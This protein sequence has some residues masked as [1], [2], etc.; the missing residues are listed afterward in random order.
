MDGNTTIGAARRSLAAFAVVAALAATGA[1][2]AESATKAQ[3]EFVST[4]DADGAP[5]RHGA[6]FVP[7]EQAQFEEAF[8]AFDTPADVDLP[9]HAVDLD[10]I[11]PAEPATRD[12]GTGVASYYGARFAGRP[13]ASGERF[14]PSDLTAAHRTLPFGSRVRVTNPRNG[15]SVI[16]RINDRGP[17]HGGRVIDL[18]RSAAEQVGI[19]RAGSGSVKLEL[20]TS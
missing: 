10:T 13:T 20:I 8:S 18:S 15:N 6:I 7:S 3:V 1:G 12:L 16:V 9:D 11:E 17:F 4:A 2:H 5:T 14:D 19:V